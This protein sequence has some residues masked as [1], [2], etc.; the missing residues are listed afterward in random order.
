MP[1]IISCDGNNLR[2]IVIGSR[3]A[4]REQQSSWAIILNTYNNQHVPT[5]MHMMRNA[6]NITWLQT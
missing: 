3:E 5:Y 2:S 6:L 4:K 1:L